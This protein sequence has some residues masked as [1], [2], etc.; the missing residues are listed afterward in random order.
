MSTGNKIIAFTILLLVFFV[1][2][3]TMSEMRVTK[4]KEGCEPTDMY[5]WPRGVKTQVYVCP[6]EEE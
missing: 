5:V 3:L 4:Q 6:P 1:G 2:M